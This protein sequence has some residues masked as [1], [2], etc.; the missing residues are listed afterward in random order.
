MNHGLMRLKDEEELRISGVR[1][2]YIETALDLFTASVLSLQTARH[3]CSYVAVWQWGSIFGQ[4]PRAPLKGIET[5]TVTKGYR[6]MG[7]TRVWVLIP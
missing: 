6:D 2:A 5:G 1:S 4:R 7:G 3:S